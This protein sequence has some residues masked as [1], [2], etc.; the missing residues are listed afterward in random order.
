MDECQSKL[1]IVHRVQDEVQRT[2]NNFII[3]AKLIYAENPNSENENRLNAT[4]IYCTEIYQYI[5][6]LPKNSIAPD[7]LDVIEKIELE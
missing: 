2:L 6:S 5:K 7:I 1:V 4:R 3:H